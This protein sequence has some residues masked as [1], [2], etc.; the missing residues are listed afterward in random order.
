MKSLLQ[1][2]AGITREDI[3]QEYRFLSSLHHSGIVQYFDVEW[4][5]RSWKAK[6]Y[7]KLCSGNTLQDL[8]DDCK[9]S[10]S[11]EFISKPVSN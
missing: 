5:P 3:E 1:V 2:S 8:I 7:M 10:S 9:R 4:Q 6:I 11:S